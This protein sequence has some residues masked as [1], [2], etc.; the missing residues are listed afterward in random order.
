MIPFEVAVS[1]TV[2]LAIDDVDEVLELVSVPETV[3]DLFDVAL[4][5]PVLVSVPEMVDN[6]FVEPVLVLGSRDSGRSR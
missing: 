5:V 1:L 2:E 4:F 3:D 6:P